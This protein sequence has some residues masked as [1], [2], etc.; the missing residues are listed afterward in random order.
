[1]NLQEL[2]QY[3]NTLPDKLLDDASQIVAET[4]T[5]YFKQTFSKKAFDGNPWA[6]GK[7]KRRGS[8]LIDSG[9]LLN[10]IHPYIIT[11]E[12]VVIAAGNAKVNY[13]KVHN[14]GYNGSVNVPAHTRHT[15]YGD[16]PVREHTRTTHIVQ[17]R[18]MGD[19]DELNKRIHEKLQAHINDKLKNK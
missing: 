7:P 15:K 12:R 6:A 8:L 17:R 4:A 16:V 5:E 19:S 1:M 14:E 3:F 18:F 11:P 9:A 13:A 10:S 2:E